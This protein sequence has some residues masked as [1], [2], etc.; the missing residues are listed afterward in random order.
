MMA[1]KQILD[2]VIAEIS[3]HAY[4]CPQPFGSVVVDAY[5]AGQL[6]PDRALVVI[7]KLLSEVER[8][9]EIESAYDYASSCAQDMDT[10]T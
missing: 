3:V 7:A 8:L 6:P 10:L 1:A 9:L 2:D 5:R 4:Q